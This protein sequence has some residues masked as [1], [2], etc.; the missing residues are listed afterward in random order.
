MTARNGKGQEVLLTGNKSL[1]YLSSLPHA[2]LSAAITAARCSGN[3]AQQHHCCQRLVSES[4][5]SLGF[6]RP[7]RANRQRNRVTCC[8]N[9]HVVST[10]RIGAAHN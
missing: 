1:H 3:R 8:T 2:A 9:P 10:F 5:V 7:V 6:C 4:V